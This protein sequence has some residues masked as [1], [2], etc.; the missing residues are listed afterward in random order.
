MRSRKS[1]PWLAWSEQ[2]GL[3]AWR[4]WSREFA[5]SVARVAEP[6]GSRVAASGEYPDLAWHRSL[7]IGSGELLTGDPRPPSPP[8]SGVVMGQRCLYAPW[9]H[10]RARPL[11]RRWKRRRS[12]QR[13]CAACQRTAGVIERWARTSPG[14][15]RARGARRRTPARL[16]DAS[17][18]SRA[19]AA[20]AAGYGAQGI[21]AAA[22]S[23]ERCLPPRRPYNARSPCRREAC[24]PRPREPRSQRGAF[25]PVLAAPGSWRQLQRRAS[26]VWRT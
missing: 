23:C 26:R 22:Q 7:R 3:P 19:T 11:E 17:R 1:T 13:A 25:Q 15:R 12:T 14:R 5:S 4:R 20:P 6:L 2:L 18:A 21:S 9:N 16:R 24:R 8:A 10:M